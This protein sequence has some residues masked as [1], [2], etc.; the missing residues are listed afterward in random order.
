MIKVLMPNIANFFISNKIMTLCDPH[1]LNYLT[2]FTNQV[3]EER[4][5]KKIVI[6]MILILMR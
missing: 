5:S 6:F 1:A 4:R 3:I 2:Q